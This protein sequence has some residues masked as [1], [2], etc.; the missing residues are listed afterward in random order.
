MPLGVA[1]PA[2]SLGAA[3]LNFGDGVR[4]RLVP[5]LGV[6]GEAVILVHIIANV[7]LIVLSFLTLLQVLRWKDRAQRAE[8]EVELLRA[9]RKGG[10]RD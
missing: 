4:R 1:D 2:A 9:L 6:E 10:A 3:G 8:A 7:C 5:L